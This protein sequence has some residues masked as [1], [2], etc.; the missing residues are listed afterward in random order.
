MAAGGAKGSGRR[1]ATVAR[2]PPSKPT[3]KNALSRARLT[4]SRLLLLPHH[5]LQAV[6][7]KVVK[8]VS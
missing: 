7:K 3:Q 5:A 6:V 4:H 2:A 8:K 1:V